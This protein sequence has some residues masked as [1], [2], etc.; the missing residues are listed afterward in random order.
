MKWFDHI[1]KKTDEALSEKEAKNLTEG[2]KSVL[3]SSRGTYVAVCEPK[4]VR[5][6]VGNDLR[7]KAFYNHEGVTDIIFSPN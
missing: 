7:E 4:G 2:T 5:L 1:E 3:F 6:L